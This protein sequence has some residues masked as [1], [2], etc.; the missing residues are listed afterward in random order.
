LMQTPFYVAFPILKDMHWQLLLPIYKHYM[1]Q[2][3]L[4]ICHPHS[5]IICIYSLHLSWH[6]F[7]HIEIPKVQISSILR[8]FYNLIHK[9]LLNP[10]QPTQLLP[11]N[12]HSTFSLTSLS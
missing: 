6:S 8:H 10:I 3:V 2:P 11:L 5:D 4:M 9:S 1:F 12:F 7:S